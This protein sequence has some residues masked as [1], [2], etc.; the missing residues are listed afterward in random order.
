MA[1]D[2]FDLV[3]TACRLR[4]VSTHQLATAPELVD[5]AILG[6]I[7]LSPQLNSEVHHVHGHNSTLR[8]HR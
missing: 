4:R 5:A 1:S 2:E 8:R 3:V 6:Q 7:P